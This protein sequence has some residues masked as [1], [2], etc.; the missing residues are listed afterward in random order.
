MTKSGWFSVFWLGLVHGTV[1]AAVTLAP[2][3][4][5]TPSPLPVDQPPASVDCA[6]LKARLQAYNQMARSHDQS[7]LGLLSDSS[8]VIHS[9]YDQLKPLEGTRGSIQKGT[10]DALDSGA[11]EIDNVTNMAFADS[12]YLAQDMDQILQSM[13][14]CLKPPP[15]IPKKP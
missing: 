11:Q 6:H 5:A 15:D 9:W 10:F 2:I 14:A 13:D 12:D 3:P 4:S 7:V 8:N 1:A